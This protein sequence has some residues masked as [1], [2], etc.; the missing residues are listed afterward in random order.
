MPETVVAPSFRTLITIILGT[1]HQGAMTGTEYNKLL[2]DEA[3]AF[4]DRVLAGTINVGDLVLHNM[5][6]TFDGN[7]PIDVFQIESI[8]SIVGNSCRTVVD[9]SLMTSVVI[10]DIH[11][12]AHCIGRLR[13]NP[14]VFTVMP[15]DLM[16]GLLALPEPALATLAST[17]CELGTTNPL[18]AA[19]QKRL[20]DISA[21]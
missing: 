18:I 17:V 19:A 13:L 12:F 11:L 8:E 2:L 9:H 14:A 1:F 20:A 4:K 15:A 5:V 7:A 3:N 6:S 16:T 10:P 21:K